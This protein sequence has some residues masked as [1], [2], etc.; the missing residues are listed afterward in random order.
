M[1]SINSYNR[2][3]SVILEMIFNDIG[4]RKIERIIRKVTNSKEKVLISKLQTK[5][6]V[7]E[8]QKNLQPINVEFIHIHNTF[9]VK[10]Y[11]SRV[12][13]LI[14]E[15]LAF[16]TGQHE[17][18]VGCI[19]SMIDL[20][21]KQKIKQVLDLGCGSAIL[22]IASSK[23][24]KCQCTAVDNDIQ[25]IKVADHN[26][27]INSVATSI[28]TMTIDI[29]DNF[30]QIPNN[31]FDLVLINIYANTINQIKFN[32]KKILKIG[33]F[34]ILSG[35]T[36]GQERM[37]MRNYQTLGFIRVNRL[38]QNGWVTLTMKRIF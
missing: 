8:S 1:Q 30:Y 10:S 13:I 27:R 6:W 4:D 29:L 12:D 25:S 23:I 28:K 36:I 7:L 19:K 2:T 17:T 18:T 37:V 16:G 32:M 5:D 20:S 14:N 21:K 24:W 26:V 3:D 9:H 34:V 38:T 11:Y 22:S 35:F 33:S 31:N 15:S